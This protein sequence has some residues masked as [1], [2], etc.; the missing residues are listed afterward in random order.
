MGHGDARLDAARDRDTVDTETIWIRVT[1]RA[2]RVPVTACVSYL[3]IVGGNGST[4]IMDAVSGRDVAGR[5]GSGPADPA[6]RLASGARGM[7]A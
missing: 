7:I 4:V 5:H 3:V 1:S 6:S 2:A